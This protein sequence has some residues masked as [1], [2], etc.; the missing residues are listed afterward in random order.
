MFT[1]Y[2]YTQY[3]TDLLYVRTCQLNDARYNT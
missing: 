1:P 2:L 3:L